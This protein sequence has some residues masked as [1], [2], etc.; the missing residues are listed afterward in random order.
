M[1][2]TKKPV[3]AFGATRDALKTINTNPGIAGAEVCYELAI[4]TGQRCRAVVPAL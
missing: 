2:G 3:L 1:D 4:Q